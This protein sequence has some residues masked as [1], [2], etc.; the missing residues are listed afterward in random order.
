MRKRWN[1]SIGGEIELKLED[2]EIIS[3][4]HNNKYEAS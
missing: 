1:A 4:R 3:Y 2:I